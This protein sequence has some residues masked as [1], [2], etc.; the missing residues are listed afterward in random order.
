MVI[1]NN[2]NMI[3]NL[4]EDISNE[5]EYIKRERY[6]MEL[7]EKRIEN[8]IKLLNKDKA[9]V[10]K[11][12]ERIKKMK[13]EIQDENN[14]L[15]EENKIVDQ[16]NQ[17]LDLKSQTIDNMRLNYILNNQYQN[18]LNNFNELGLK[19]MPNFGNNINK[20]NN[21]NNND[22]VFNRTDEFKPKNNFAQTFS[23][24]NQ[25]GRRLNADEYFEKLKIREKDNE[26][27][28]NFLIDGKNFLK[29][30]RED[31]KQLDNN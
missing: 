27:I 11:E 17:G 3:N 23:V 7:M 20:N 6:N 10:E 19:T 5:K 9:Y 18:N 2:L 12:K 28:E 1:N 25:G 15:N 24:F 4:N 30:I 14:K 31:S 16:E 8:N 21:N 26:D 29:N 22:F 13:M